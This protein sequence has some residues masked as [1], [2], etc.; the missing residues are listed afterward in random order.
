M[1]RKYI[2]KNQ[3]GKTV[4]LIVSNQALDEAKAE[5]FNIDTMPGLNKHDTLLFRLAIQMCD[6]K[7]SANGEV[8]YLTSMA[9][10]EADQPT[11]AAI[12]YYKLSEHPLNLKKHSGKELAV[13]ENPKLAAYELNQQPV[14]Y[15]VLT[16]FSPSTVPSNEEVDRD[17]LIAEVR[18][19]NVKAADAIKLVHNH[20]DIFTQFQQEIVGEYTGDIDK[21]IAD[22]HQ[23]IVTKF[24]PV[25]IEQIEPKSQDLRATVHDYIVSA[26]DQKMMAENTLLAVALHNAATDFFRARWLANL[27]NREQL[28]KDRLAFNQLFAG[29]AN[30]SANYDI[31]PVNETI[32]N[33][34]R[35]SKDDLQTL[36]S[37]L[38]ND[39]YKKYFTLDP[40]IDAFSYIQKRLNNLHATLPHF[41]RVERQW[42]AHKFKLNSAF[43]EQTNAAVNSKRAELFSNESM[44]AFAGISNLMRDRSQE[45]QSRAKVERDDY[46]AR[47]PKPKKAKAPKKAGPAPQQQALPARDQRSF[48]QRNKGTIISIGTGL[49]IGAGAAA[50]I[51]FAPIALPI[52]VVGGIAAAVGVAVVGVSAIVG[53]IIDYRRNKKAKDQYGDVSSVDSERAGLLADNDFR[54]D[55][56]TT[57]QLAQHGLNGNGT[58]HTSAY[59]SPRSSTHRA[60]MFSASGNDNNAP[61]PKPDV[62]AQFEYSLARE[63][64]NQY[65]SDDEA[66]HAAIMKIFK[67]DCGRN[68]D[69][70]LERVE[71]MDPAPGRAAE[72]I[73]A[74]L[75][76]TAPL[77][78]DLDV[79]L[80]KG[81]TLEQRYNLEHEIIVVSGKQEDSPSMKKK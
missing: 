68:M 73:K 77:Y 5:S 17:A 4:T 78:D 8:F 39:S 79:S 27:D 47:Q 9:A 41:D 1:L 30:I 62:K 3:Q 24:A 54:P 65:A 58:T 20:G 19:V 74:A 69:E 75:K 23:D 55:N 63:I 56:G 43:I 66:R 51:V 53:R 36:I 49:L 71:T 13:K 37:R 64:A 50:A 16:N 12:K 44:T 26:H 15:P 45:L 80:L 32:D 59:E 10:P 57:A 14:K 33:F 70:F 61:P 6:N 11:N 81:S 18:K 76:E 2:V 40:T 7:K 21:G 60:T 48:W 72:K 35:L 25:F 42:I 46:L 67:E 29:I 38:L 34:R 22:I 52:L 31:S 28:E